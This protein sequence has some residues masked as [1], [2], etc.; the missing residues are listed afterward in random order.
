MPC[1]NILGGENAVRLYEALGMSANSIGYRPPIKVT[2]SDVILSVK[3]YED[4]SRT[5]T[6]ISFE[7][8][9]FD[10]HDAGR[11]ILKRGASRGSVTTTLYPNGAVRVVGEGCGPYSNSPEIAYKDC[12]KPREASEEHEEILSIAEKVYTLVRP[13]FPGQPLKRPEL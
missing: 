5:Y 13:W 7:S 12:Y 9:S 10:L 2:Y 1:M 6:E 4:F 3:A 11:I 8:G